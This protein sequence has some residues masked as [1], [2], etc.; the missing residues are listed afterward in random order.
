MPTYR[1][2]VNKQATGNFVTG[3]KA[4]DA[5]MNAASSISLN[6]DD[7]IQLLEVKPTAADDQ[8]IASVTDQDL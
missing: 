5:Y 4:D 7:D 2:F 3:T 6:E 8:S 1:V